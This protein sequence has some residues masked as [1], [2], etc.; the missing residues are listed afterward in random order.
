MQQFSAHMFLIVDRVPDISNPSKEKLRVLVIR[1]MHFNVYNSQ[2][3][4]SL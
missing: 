1:I 3:I 4:E 2:P